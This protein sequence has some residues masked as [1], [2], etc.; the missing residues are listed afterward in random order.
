[1]LKLCLFVCVFSYIRLYMKPLK[2]I[3]PPTK[4]TSELLNLQPSRNN[5]DADVDDDP[6]LV[7]DPIS[8]SNLDDRIKDIKNRIELRRMLAQYESGH[9]KPPIYYTNRVV[10]ANEEDYEDPDPEGD[11]NFDNYPMQNDKR[12]PAR[13]IVRNYHKY[14]LMLPTYIHL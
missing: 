2:T 14:E 1:M 10:N 12:S 7:D 4:L 3:Q 5:F 6:A 11:T 9:L 8:S 13:F